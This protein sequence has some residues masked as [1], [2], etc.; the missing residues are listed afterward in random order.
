MKSLLLL[1]VLLLSA[2]AYVSGTAI[3]DQEKL[4]EI[5]KILQQHVEQ[6]AKRCYPKGNWGNKYAELHKEQLVSPTGKRLVAIPHL[7]GMSWYPLDLRSVS[8]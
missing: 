2:L 3:S 4:T 1:I 6:D 8:V 5:G 7:S